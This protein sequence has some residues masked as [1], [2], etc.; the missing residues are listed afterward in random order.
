MLGS[1]RNSGWLLVMG[2]PGGGPAGSTTFGGG[3][4]ACVAHPARAVIA[5]T[6]AT[7]QSGPE[8][9]T[10]LDG[11]EKRIAFGFLFAS[12]LFAGWSFAWQRS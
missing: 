11:A 10:N 1:R 2:L 8:K 12:W 9:A 5:S 3:G 4:G 7:A 6:A